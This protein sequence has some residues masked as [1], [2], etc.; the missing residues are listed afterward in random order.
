VKGWTGFN[1]PM[2]DFYDRGS[3]SSAAMNVND[4]FNSCSGIN[5]PINTLYK[6]FG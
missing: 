6:G 2:I 4:F 5:F 3:E 1:W